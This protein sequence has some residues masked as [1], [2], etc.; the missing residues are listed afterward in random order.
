M[1]REELNL[2][3]GKGRARSRRVEISSFLKERGMV[4]VWHETQ[5]PGH[6]REIA[7]SLPEESRVVA[8]GGDGTIS[9]VASACM[10]SRRVLG[11]LPAG[12]GN[13]YAK[14]LGA[15]RNLGRALKVLADGRVGLADT[16]E[17]NGRPFVNGLG[18][19]FDAQV[20]EGV[21]KAPAYL[22]GAGGYLW[23]VGRILAGL[24]CYEADLRLDGREIRSKT[25]LVAVALGTIYGGAFRL[26]PL[27]RLDD[28]LF[29]VIYSSEVSRA[30]VI[31]L[32]PGVLRGTHLSHEKVHFARARE[33]EVR[34]EAT[35]PAHADGEML[36]PAPL[37]S[38]RII[39]QNLRVIMA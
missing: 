21:E 31:G 27:A 38:A 7:R 29:D 18:I 33:V 23:S 19:G 36:E 16:G 26:A 24:Q 15:G 34:M 32:I 12:S 4:A 37:F 11:V 35:P 39:P 13:D 20:A 25:I 28:G 8:V 30:E 9:E 10:G 14:A 6:A 2:I 17:V 22:G 1:G 3:A 5:G